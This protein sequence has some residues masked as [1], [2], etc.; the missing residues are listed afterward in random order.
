MPKKKNNLTP[1]KAQ[2][3]LL[4]LPFSALNLWREAL[5]SCAIEGNPAAREMADA[6]DRWTSGKA[7]DEDAVKLAT[8][9][10]MGEK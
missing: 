2:N 7:S 3:Y 6:L 9:M 5:A 10:Q 8:M 1:T 4:S